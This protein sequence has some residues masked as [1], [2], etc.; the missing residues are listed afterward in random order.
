MKTIKTFLKILYFYI[1]IGFFNLGVSSAYLILRDGRLNPN[2]IDPMATIFFWPISSFS[3]A[4]ELFGEEGGQVW[5][6]FSFAG[7]FLFIALVIFLARGDSEKQS[8]G[9]E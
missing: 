8:V 6:Y 9:D 2:L 1:L 3:S 4:K 7:I 5:N